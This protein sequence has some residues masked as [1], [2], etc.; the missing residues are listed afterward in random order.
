MRQFQQHISLLHWILL[1]AL[2]CMAVGAWWYQIGL[3]VWIAF[4]LLVFH[5]D[6]MLHSCY[7]VTP[8]ELRL[9]KSRFRKPL[10]I[11]LH[12]VLRIERLESR[13]LFGIKCHSV[14][15]LTYATDDLLQH[16]LETYI[17]PQTPDEFVEFL[18][19][20]KIALALADEEDC[21]DAS[22]DEDSQAHV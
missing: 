3:L 12:R 11:S 9:R 15:V 21:D 6:R 20:K 8:Q 22:S 16:T 1:F 19:K 18:R 13:Q 5:L 14:L 4:T 2:A 10:I 7:I 17:D